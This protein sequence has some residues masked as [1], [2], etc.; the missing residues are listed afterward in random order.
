VAH[1]TRP[2]GRVVEVDDPE[3]IKRLTERRGFRNSTPAE[4]E[5]YHSAKTAARLAAERSEPTPG[6]IYYKTVGPGADGYGMS[7]DLIKDELFGLG[8][9]LD[10]NFANQ[11]VGLLY[12]YPNGLL[13][14]SNDVRLVMT[15]FESDKIP[16]DWKDYLALADEVIVPSKWCA[17]VFGRAGIKTTVVPLGYND[18]VFKYIERPI[19]VEAGQ[20]YTFIH[21]SAF[22]IRKGFFEVLEAFSRE[23]AH[24]E[25]V[26][27]ILK[28]TDRKPPI[29]IVKSE[30]PNIE[31]ICGE[32]SEADLCALL[33]RANCM[34]YPSRGEGF[35][36]TPLE[37][38]ATGMPAIVPNAH[39]IS[40]YFNSNYML[41]VKVAEKCPGLV[42][43]FRGQDIGEMVICDVNDLRQQMR[44]AYNNQNR[45]HQ[46]GRFASDYVQRYT[47]QETAGRLADILR[48]WQK[49]D[50]PTRGDAKFLPVEAI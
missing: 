34:V 26:R 40:E 36:I 25:P 7:R 16:E 3:S 2:D 15:M 9:K 32:L 43:K 49:A 8:V 6:G 33:G 31:V 38:M 39:G 37:A 35:G 47:Y 5:T 29:P 50:V 1:L 48:R 14:M 24:N 12:S 30:Y 45:M 44:F 17:D 19:P 20:P 42:G 27:L 28:T 10:E 23:F 22:N 18:R 41:E 13:Q 21:Y 46:M 11:K 4:I